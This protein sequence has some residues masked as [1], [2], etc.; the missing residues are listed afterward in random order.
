MKAINSNEVSKEALK[1]IK[2][3]KI[4]IIKREN[5]NKKCFDCKK[6]NPEIISLY[7]G[8]FICKECAKNIHSKLNKN[9]NLLID[10][11][12][13]NLSLKGIQYLYYGGNKKLEDFINNEYPDLKYIAKK[14]FYSSK[15][16]DYYRQ[17]LNYLINGKKSPIKPLIDKKVIENSEK[18]TINIKNDF[19]KKKNF[20]NINILNDYYQKKNK[21]KFFL[22]EN[23]SKDNYKAKENFYDK[24][25]ENN[26][27]NLRCINNSERNKQEKLKNLNIDMNNK[28]IKTIILDNES[29]YFYVSNNNHINNLNITTI[30]KEIP[31][32]HKNNSVF[33]RDLNLSTFDNNKVYIK[34][35]LLTSANVKR[36][37]LFFKKEKTRMQKFN[38]PN[39]YINRNKNSILTSKTRNS[40]LLNNYINSSKYF[41]NDYENTSDNHREFNH[42]FFNSLN[43]LDNSS[44]FDNG[45]FNSSF[46]FKKK[47]LKSSFSISSKKLKND[48]KKENTIFIDKRENFQ[49]IQNIKPKII[50]KKKN[51]LNCLTKRPIL[52]DKLDFMFYTM[53]DIQKKE[54]ISKK[55]DE[56]NKGNAKQ[57]I[58][59]RFSL[60]KL[61]NQIIKIKNN[62]KKGNNLKQNT[63]KNL[64]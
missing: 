63:Y 44:N 46:I 25:Y 57:I 35:Y 56:K 19:E 47:N 33:T 64:I 13:R 12:L 48:N 16:M 15:E 26:S 32:Y 20:K 40:A 18:K 42:T 24:I 22:D 31:L 9:I 62:H 50:K 53:T 6:L 61:L 37:S 8:I 2:E 11:N 60:K 36:N 54:D 49:I 17:R 58:N 27:V 43:S 45:T 38:N 39:I 29:N 10:N 7:N 28:N 34:P 52:K 14:E 23:I 41:R 51:L 5:Y 21:N 59:N 30:N 4:I 55:N 1:K 3:K